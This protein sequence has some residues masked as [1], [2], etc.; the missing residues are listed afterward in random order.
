MSVKYF[1]ELIDAATVRV[2]LCCQETSFGLLRKIIEPERPFFVRSSTGRHAPIDEA[3]GKAAV[4]EVVMTSTSA[5]VRMTH[6]NV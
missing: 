5:A 3:A 4:A 6:H 2:L 1:V